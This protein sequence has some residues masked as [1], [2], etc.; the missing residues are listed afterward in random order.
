MESKQVRGREIG[1]DRGRGEGET[2]GGRG[3]GREKNPTTHTPY[4]MQGESGGLR[5]G[6]AAKVLPKAFR[7]LEEVK[8]TSPRQPPRP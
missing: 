7:R 6:T 4:K 1:R 3:R 5:H 2:Q 8:A